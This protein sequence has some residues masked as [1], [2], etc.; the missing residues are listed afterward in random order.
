MSMNARPR[1]LMCPPDKFDVGYVINPWMEGNVHKS[2]PELAASQ[3]EAF[4]KL[5]SKCADVALIEPRPGWPDMVFT[6][7]AGIVVGKRFVL[8]R[9]LHPE[10]QGEEP[11]FKKWFKQQGF[12]IFELPPDLP[13]EGA[14]DALIDRENG[15]LWAAY[16]FRSEL[17]SHPRLAKWLNL[18]V[19]SLRLIDPRFYHLDTCFCP[20]T[21]GWL[22]YY[23]QAFDARSNRQIEQR[24]PP[25]KRIAV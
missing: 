1:F 24:I 6:A 11:F 19:I 22:L 21:G 5:L 7:N 18:E 9:F 14:G 8:S 10:R 4:Q 23:P 20:L 25:E 12:E 2:S 17:D 3:W 15:C 16:G 13:F